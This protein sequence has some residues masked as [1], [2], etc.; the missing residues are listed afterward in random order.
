MIQIL[1][2]ERRTSVFT[3]ALHPMPMTRI[4]A[5]TWARQGLIALLALCL[6][7]MTGC[8]NRTTADGMVIPDPE[9]WASAV[10]KIQDSRNVP[11][12]FDG[13]YWSSLNGNG[14]KHLTT[15]QFFP[16][17]RCL[18]QP[19]AVESDKPI[20]ESIMRGYM[21]KSN[22]YVGRWWSAAEGTFIIK[23]Y[24]PSE[25]GYRFFNHRCTVANGGGTFT[26]AEKWDEAYDTTWTMPIEQGTLRFVPVPDIQRYQTEW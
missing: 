15:V 10:V 4:H 24:A 23:W 20:S 17:G 26:T 21:D 14:E 22:C 6:S 2:P 19:I 5:D 3:E 9:A 25:T 16:N 7:A 18:S 1:A 12:R 11:L 13:V 8:F